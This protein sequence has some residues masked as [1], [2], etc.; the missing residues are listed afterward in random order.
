MTVLTIRSLASM[1]L[2]LCVLLPTHVAAQ[3]P[4]KCLEIEGILAD[5]CNG[6]PCTANE[7]QNEMVRFRTGPDP[8]SIG[9]ITVNWPNLSW[10][11]LIQNATTADLTAQINATIENC[12]WLLE[13]PGGV[14][15]PGSPVILVT[16]IV[17][18]PTANSFSNLTDTLYIVFQNF[19]NTSST[20]GHFKNFDVPPGGVISEVPFQ[21]GGFRTMR[22]YVGPGQACGDTATYDYHLLVNEYGTYGGTSAENNGAAIEFSWP[23]VPQVTYVNY[24]CQ[25]PFP[26]FIVQPEVDGSLCGGSGTVNISGSVTGG[27]FISV[28]WSG[29]TGVFGDP[30]SLSTTYTAGPGDGGTVELVLCVQTDCVDPICASV[31]VPAGTGPTITITPDGPLAIC[32]GEDVVLTASGADAYVWGD[33]QTS[34]AITATAVGT[35]TVTGTNACGT[36]SASIEVTQGVGISV[37][38]AGPSEICP[39]A[40]ATLTASGATSYLWS[41]GDLTPATTINAPGTYSVTGSTACGS[42]TETIVVAP[43]VAPSVSIS[44]DL[45]FCTGASTALTATGTGTFNWTGGSTG[46]N[47]VVSVGGAYTVTATNACGSTS[48]SVNVVESDGPEVAITGSLSFCNGQ[49]TTLVATGA[50]DYTWST[51]ASGATVSVN[52]PGTVTVTGTNDCGNDGASVIITLLEPPVVEVSGEDLLCPNGQVVLTAMSNASV[53]WNTGTSGPSITVSNAGLFI[54]T[55][56]NGCGSDSDG[57]QVTASPLDA[58]FTPSTTSGVA[59]LTVVF[60]NSTVPPAAAYTWDFDG[61]GMSTES[62]PVHL[63]EVPG[64]YVIT[65]EAVLDGCVALADAVITVTAPP[66]GSTSSVLIPNVFTPNGDPQNSIFFVTAVNIVKMNMLIYNRWGQKVHELRRAGESWDARSLSG[67]LVPDGTY[68][69]TFSAEGADG[70]QYDLSG[71]ITLIR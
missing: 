20:T 32:A 57:F 15:P 42:T 58:A 29:G 51:G 48:S 5:A 55:A 19:T 12:G 63:F 37:T 44:G 4:T 38:I 70:K 65:L 31:S 46:P 28:L 49:S 59:P 1:V 24:G 8:V 68:F 10:L 7:P 36:G 43:G 2:L 69:Y 17:M 9:S 34:S 52:T 67:D 21:T 11:G 47:L 62:D 66:T 45:E 39:G 23:G 60:N 33:G 71:H 41:T 25:A 13:P 30:N 40:S 53:T 26:Q 18:C 61:E 14:I 16:S 35:Y 64:V 54:A 50:D 56:T 27:P 22:M 3:T 6:A